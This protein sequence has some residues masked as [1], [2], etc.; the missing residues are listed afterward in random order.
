MAAY[1]ALAA[2]AAATLDGPI[3]LATLILLAGL[4][5][6]SWIAALKENQQD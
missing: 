2:L 6:K 1:L 4:A 3:R 5:L